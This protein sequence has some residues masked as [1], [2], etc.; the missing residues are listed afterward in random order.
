[1]FLILLLCCSQCGWLFLL[2]SVLNDSKN[3]VCT[4]CKVL[5]LH[6]LS[7]IFKSLESHSEYNQELDLPSERVILDKCDLF[8]TYAV[9]AI[10][11]GWHPS[12]EM[13]S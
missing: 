3:N 6:Y 7:S 11:L 5:Y 9:Q 4:F 1:M 10:G 8:P 12:A 13:A 2:W